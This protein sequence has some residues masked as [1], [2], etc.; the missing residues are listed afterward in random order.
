MLCNDTPFINASSVQKAIAFPQFMVEIAEN[1]LM[2]VDM[3]SLV[4]FWTMDDSV[5]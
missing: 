5:G 2:F 1:C 3:T 4:A